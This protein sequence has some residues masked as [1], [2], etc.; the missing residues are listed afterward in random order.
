MKF[1]A[2]VITNKDS[3]KQILKKNMFNDFFRMPDMFWNY[4]FIGT[5]WVRLLSSANELHIPTGS[6]WDTPGVENFFKHT[7]IHGSNPPCANQTYGL[8]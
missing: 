7:I 1:H 4:V 5:G 2:D 6:K 8:N 3:K